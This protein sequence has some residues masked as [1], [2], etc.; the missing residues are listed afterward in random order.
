[1]LSAQHLPTN[2]TL[3]IPHEPFLVRVDSSGKIVVEDQP[4][5]PSIPYNQLDMELIQ[6]TFN[7]EYTTH[8]CSTD[9]VYPQQTPIHPI[10]TTPSGR[11][12]YEKFS[13]GQPLC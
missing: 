7:E 8:V 12:L 9:M 11:Y 4:S 1:V 2:L 10:W 5:L 13:F 6:P 3:E